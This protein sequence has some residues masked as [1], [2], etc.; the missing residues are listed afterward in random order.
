M[1]NPTDIRLD[2]YY[3]HDSHSGVYAGGLTIKDLHLTP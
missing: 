3:T 1:T 2:S